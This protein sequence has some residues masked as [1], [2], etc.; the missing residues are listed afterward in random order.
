MEEGREKE[1]TVVLR[2]EMPSVA[3]ER[4]KKAQL[5]AEWMRDDAVILNV[6]HVLIKAPKLKSASVV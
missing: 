2:L 1:V 4:A 5:T 6:A 3:H